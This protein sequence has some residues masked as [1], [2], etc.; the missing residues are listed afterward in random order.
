LQAYRPAAVWDLGP[1]DVGRIA[2][3]SLSSSPRRRPGPQEVS[4]SPLPPELPASAGM[5]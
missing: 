3:W 5:T 4:G 1:L 2:D